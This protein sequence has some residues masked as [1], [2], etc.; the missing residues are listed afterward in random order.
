MN[1]YEK[2]IGETLKKVLTEEIGSEK[3]RP[4]SIYVSLFL[5]LQGLISKET[6]K[7]IDVNIFYTYFYS[8]HND[9]HEEL[10]EDYISKMI[11]DDYVFCEKFGKVRSDE[12]Y[13]ILSMD[14]NPWKHLAH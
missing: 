8:A 3:E 7:K 10:Y 9:I 1:N 14:L 2:T 5:L 12:L 6:A 11:T 4:N 13:D